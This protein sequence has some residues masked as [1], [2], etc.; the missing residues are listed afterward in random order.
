[1]LNLD[2]LSD[3]H[4]RHDL[5]DLH[6][7]H[8]FRNDRHDHRARGDEDVHQNRYRCNGYRDPHDLHDGRLD[9]CCGHHNGYRDPCIGHFDPCDLDRHG[10]RA[11]G[12]EDAHRDL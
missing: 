8:D 7:R 6:G 2:D 4:G 12:D 5:H 10:H 3:L 11:C 1:F 9:E